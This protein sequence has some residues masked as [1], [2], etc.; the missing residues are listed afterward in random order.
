MVSHQ[1]NERIIP[2]I[3]MAWYLTTKSD[4]IWFIPSKPR[5]LEDDHPGSM[6]HPGQEGYVFVRAQLP[7]AGTLVSKGSEVVLFTEQTRA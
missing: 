1:I 7:A 4:G 6:S 5:I 2:T 3:S